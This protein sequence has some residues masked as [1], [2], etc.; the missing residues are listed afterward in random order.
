MC[1]VKIILILH[2]RPLQRFTR[3]LPKRFFLSTM[4]FERTKAT[5]F[6]KLGGGGGGGGYF[7]VMLVLISSLVT[8]NLS[9][10]LRLFS[11]YMYLY[12]LA[13]SQ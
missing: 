2:Q 9:K 8:Y 4:I 5:Y 12:F 13:T 10:I 3:L 11:F 1:G 6:M 7:T